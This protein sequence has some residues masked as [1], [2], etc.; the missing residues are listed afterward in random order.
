MPDDHD[1]VE[2]TA[3]AAAGGDRDA[4]EAL[5]AQVRPEVLR[6]CGRFLPN[7]ENAEEAC[8]DTLLALATGIEA[9]DGRSSFRTWLY[10]VAANR[11]RSTYHAL[12][13]RWMVETA[14]ALPPDRAD[15]ART[16]VIAGTRLDLLEGLDAIGA[17][18]AEPVA[19]RD[20]MG[21]SYRE[22]AQ[23][24]GL[25]EGTVKSRIHEGRRRL[26]ARLT[27]AGPHSNGS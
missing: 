20:V 16:S 19:L 21:L 3:R 14:S 6:L 12:R 27:D 7:R 2:R 22:V 11:S 1:V 10:R 13:R 24:L 23:L 15:P 25:P 17:D 5:L 26:R 9:F 18:L 8:Q 4:L